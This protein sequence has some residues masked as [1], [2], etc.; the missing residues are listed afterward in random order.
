VKKTYFA[1]IAGGLAIAAVVL[2][3]SRLRAQVG[4]TG[5]SGIPLSSLAGSFAGEGGNN[6]GVCFNKN[7]MAVQSC[8]K[9]PMAQIVPFV[10]NYTSQGTADTKGNSCSEIFDT[11]ASLFPGPQPAIVNNL[12]FVGTTTSYN[13]ATGSGNTSVK[14]YFVGPGVTC[15][16]A[17]FINTAKAPVFFTETAHFVVSESG[18]RLD[19]VTLT[20]HT[21]SPV[22]FAAGFVGHSLS[23]RQ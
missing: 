20:F 15:K 1:V 6:Y 17:T 11:G 3:D 7:L 4:S 23:L 8:S 5:S 10:D 22:D 12:I 13:P 19:S 21:I 9:T 16:G 18:N 2:G 14:S